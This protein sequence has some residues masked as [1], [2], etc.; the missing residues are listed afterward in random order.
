MQGE[1]ELLSLEMADMA[2]RLNIPSEW[3]RKEGEKAALRSSVLP[4]T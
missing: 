4:K 1:I 3:K 2:W